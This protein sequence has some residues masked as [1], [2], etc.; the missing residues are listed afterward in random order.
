[1]FAPSVIFLGALAMCSTQVY[2]QSYMINFFVTSKTP[3]T[4]PNGR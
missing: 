4:N 1:M 2:I 3:I